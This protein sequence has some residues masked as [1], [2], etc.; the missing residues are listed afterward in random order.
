MDE[1]NIILSEVKGRK[2]Q[3]WI[4]QTHLEGGTK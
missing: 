4:F 2:A 1:E 3:V